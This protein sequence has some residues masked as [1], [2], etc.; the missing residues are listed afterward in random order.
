MYAGTCLTWKHAIA[1]EPQGVP[2]TY[3]GVPEA[4][5]DHGSW[6]FH[7]RRGSDE[8]SVRLVS[9]EHKRLRS[10]YV[11]GRI[12]IVL[13]AR[14]V[15]KEAFRNFETAYPTNCKAKSRIN[16]TSSLVQNM[17]ITSPID[18]E[19]QAYRSEGKFLTLVPMLSS[20]QL[21]ISFF[22]MHQ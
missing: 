3:I 15:S 10:I 18:N 13:R 19:R 6:Y 4:Q 1:M 8:E 11:R 14:W 9:I 5:Q 2:G 7:R 12:K 21:S 16:P 22:H 20:P 17:S